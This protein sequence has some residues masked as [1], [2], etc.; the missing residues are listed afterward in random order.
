[1]NVHSAHMPAAAILPA[2]RQMR[3]IS[4]ATLRATL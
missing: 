1:M 3:R 4:P 2:N